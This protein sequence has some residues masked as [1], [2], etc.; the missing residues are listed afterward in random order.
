[1]I[2]SHFNEYDLTTSTLMQSMKLDKNVEDGGRGGRS[3]RRLRVGA[4]I[5][6][7]ADSHIPFNPEQEYGVSGVKRY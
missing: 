3:V 1:M 2:L 6:R 4:E 7:L 5:V